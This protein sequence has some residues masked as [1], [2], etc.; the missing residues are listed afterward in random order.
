MKLYVK[1]LTNNLSQEYSKRPASLGFNKFRNR[2]SSIRK[3]IDEDSSITKNF[4]DF[5]WHDSNNNPENLVPYTNE[6]SARISAL[7]EGVDVG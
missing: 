1:K 4:L 7:T 6:M 3:T 2:T 5:L